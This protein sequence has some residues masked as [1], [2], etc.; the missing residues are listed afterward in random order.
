MGTNYFTSG[1]QH[2]WVD[3]FHD[4]LEADAGSFVKMAWT[5]FASDYEEC[6]IHAQKGHDCKEPLRVVLVL[7]VKGRLLQGKTKRSLARKVARIKMI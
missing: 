7:R 4:A 2:V 1:A 5:A 6:Q 3:L